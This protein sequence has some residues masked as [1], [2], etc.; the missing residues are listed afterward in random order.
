MYFEVDFSTGNL[1]GRPGY[2][3]TWYLNLGT[4][5]HTGKLIRSFAHD[6]VS[7]GG[8]RTRSA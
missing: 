4:A 1:Y 8:V 7:G 6:S 2:L 3:R 5:V